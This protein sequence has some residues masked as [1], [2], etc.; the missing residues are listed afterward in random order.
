[1]NC[2]KFESKLERFLAETLSPASMQECR[3]HLKFCSA[4]RELYF[5]AAKESVAVEPSLEEDLI[6]SVLK[7]TSGGSCGQVH[8]LLPDYVYNELSPVQIELVDRHLEKCSSCQQIHKTMEELAEELPCLAEIDPGK[9]FTAECLLTFQSFENRFRPQKPL[10][11]QMWSRLL[12][13]PRFTWEAAYVLTLAFFIIFKTLVFIPGQT[14]TESNNNLQ[15]IPAQAYVS[16]AG[17]IEEQYVKFRVSVNASQNRW[18]EASLKGKTELLSAISWMSD[19]TGQ[20]WQ[21]ASVVAV[22][23]PR[24]IWNGVVSAFEGI[25]KKIEPKPENSTDSEPFLYSCVLLDD[26]DKRNAKLL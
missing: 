14:P 12:A 6:Q 26:L 23:F 22:G 15:V 5:F 10:F 24:S 3:A 13:R 19:K 11:N 16:V 4:C 20:Y 7:K 8:E 18:L 25:L 2:R 21:S 17:A 9:S 1:M